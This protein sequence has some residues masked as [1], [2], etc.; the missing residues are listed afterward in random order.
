MNWYLFYRRAR[1]TPERG[2]NA[3]RGAAYRFMDYYIK[4]ALVCQGF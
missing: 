2:K 1:K 3:K 4:T